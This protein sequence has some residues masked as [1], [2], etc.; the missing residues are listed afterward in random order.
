MGKLASV[1]R[2]YP[3]IVL[4]ARDT[5]TYAKR[6]LTSSLVLSE[7]RLNQNAVRGLSLAAVA[8][9]RVSVVEMRMLTDIESNFAA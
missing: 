9:D 2:V 8:G 6:S 4:C 1:I 5:D 3:G 7:S